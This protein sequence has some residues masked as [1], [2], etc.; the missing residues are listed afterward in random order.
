METQHGA[1]LLREAKKAVKGHFPIWIHSNWGIDLHFFAQL[2]GHVPRLRETLAEIDVL[3]VEGRRDEDLSRRLGYSGVVQTFPSVGGG[4][5]IPE[6]ALLPASARKKILVK[7]TQ[8]I[9]RRGLVALRA[10]ERCADLLDGYEIILYS[11]N[12]ITRVAAE[13]FRGRTNLN[14]SVL[15]HVSHEEIFG[16]NAEA[17]ISLCVNMSDGLPNAMLEAMLMGAF[18]IQSDTSLAGEWITH[19][20]T[21][22]LV[23]PE[24]PDIIELALRE[25]LSND[26][27]VDHA[28]TVNRKRIADDLSFE[29]IRNSVIGM[30]RQATEPKR[31][32]K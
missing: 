16:L 31:I 26:E 30:Y 32:D 8:D 14:I 24:D 3:L 20:M 17:R 28:A 19:G 10:L 12:E 1:Y 18:P 22:M 23:P 25:A 5:V 15:S 4:F 13:L 11:S 7:G 27:M 9:V 6:T 2:S 21:G 29:K